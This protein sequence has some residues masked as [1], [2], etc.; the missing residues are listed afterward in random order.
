VD[1]SG[2][3]C[4][5]GDVATLI[6]T[7]GKETLSASDIARAADTIHYEFLTR[8]NPLIERIIV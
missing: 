3:P 4:R 2:I 8:L 7:D 1:V 5:P 6:G